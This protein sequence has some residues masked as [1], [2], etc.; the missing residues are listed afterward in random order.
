MKTP[1]KPGSEYAKQYA[2]VQRG[3]RNSQ[4]PSAPGP[5]MTSSPRAKPRPADLELKSKG[6]LKSSPRAQPRP[7]KPA[8]KPYPGNKTK[9]KNV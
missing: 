4:P 8:A 6:G 2:T 1:M 3:N 9:P 5:G 7:T